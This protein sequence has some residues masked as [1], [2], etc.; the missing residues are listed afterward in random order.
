MFFF[1]FIPNVG[2]LNAHLCIKSIHFYQ[3]HLHIFTFMQL[4]SEPIVQTDGS[5]QEQETGESVLVCPQLPV[6]SE[7]E[8]NL[9]CIFFVVVFFADVTSLGLAYWR[10]WDDSLYRM[11]VKSDYLI[12]HSLPVSSN[13]SG[14]SSLTPFIGMAQICHSLI[15]N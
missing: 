15:V 6:P 3:E 12:R 5:S 10:L 4:S 13:H 7:Q 14:C 11:G 8:W 9:R 1:I 2:D